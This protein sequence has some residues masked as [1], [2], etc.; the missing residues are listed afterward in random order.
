MASHVFSLF[1]FIFFLISVNVLGLA[2]LVGQFPQLE[3]LNDDPCL[4]PTWTWIECNSDAKPRI[5]ALN[6]S[7]NS[8]SGPIPSFLGTLPY[9]QE[10]NLADNL[11]TGLVPDSI[12]CN[13]NLKLSLTGNTDLYTSGSCSTSIN[14]PSSTANTNTGSSGSSDSSFQTTPR[15]RSSRKK[16]NLP[17]I[18]G[19]PVSVFSVFW[20]AV[21][22]FALCRHKTK[23]AAAIAEASKVEG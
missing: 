5:I 6:L 22:V 15:A 9:L 7:E 1:F 17:I 16:S 20:I 3:E 18:V 12:A 10:L 2:S 14:I 23:T 8:L 19:A 4:P 21:G 11:F 13:K